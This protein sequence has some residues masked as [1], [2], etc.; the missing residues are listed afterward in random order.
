MS[1][2]NASGFWPKADEELYPVTP[3]AVR[4]G[5][6]TKTLRNW[7]AAGR[8]GHVRLGRTVRVPLSEINRTIAEGYRPAR[9]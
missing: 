5:I 9:V 2:K 3:A 7:I 4:L 8:I 1:L 6:K